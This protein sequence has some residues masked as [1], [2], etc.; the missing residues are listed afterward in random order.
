MNV[1]VRPEFAGSCSRFRLTFRCN[2]RKMT[3]YVRAEDWTRSA[4]A[5]AL[6]L[7]QYVYKVTRRS[8]RFIHY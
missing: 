5:D 7:L 1:D 4:A 2:G 3:E 8:V 6:D